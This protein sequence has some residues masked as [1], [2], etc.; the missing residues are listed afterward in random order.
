MASVAVIIPVYNRPDYLRAAL[1]SV[2]AQTRLPDEV[3]VV[4]DGSTDNTAAVAQE[5]PGVTFI[6]QQNSGASAARNRGIQA[7]TSEWVAF[8]DS[9]DAWHPDKLRLQ[10]HALEQHP[11]CD[12]CTSNW[13][14]LVVPETGSRRDPPSDLSPGLDIAA[15]LRGSLRLPPGTVLVRRTRLVELGG[16]DL[17]APPCEDWDLWLRLAAAGCKF[18]LEPSHLLLIR[19]HDSNI[20]NQSFRM[21]KAEV[22]AW[23]KNIAPRYG[24]LA[25][26][27]RRRAA[28]AHFLGRVALVERE[29]RRPH[30]GV[31]ARSLLLSPLG[32]WRRYRIFLHM[33]LTRVGVLRPATA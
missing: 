13:Q 10:L 21:M 8:L 16:F 9:D 27:L 26:P 19:S 12:V 3:L 11:E 33:L 17:S 2:F 7:A 20:S 15:G 1:D 5:Y 22:R 4:D 32:E 24:A 14:Q 29:Q 30:L 31:M 28:R 25:R 6:R 18:V 23:D